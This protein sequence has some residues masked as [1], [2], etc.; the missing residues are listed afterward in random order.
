MKRPSRRTTIA[1]SVVAALL[2]ISSSRV[3]GRVT[4][5]NRVPIRDAHVWVAEDGEV[6]LRLRTDENGRFHAWHRP[7]AMHRGR[8]L[9][10]ARGHVIM[11]REHV[12]RAW[13]N[14]FG[15]GQRHSPFPPS[16]D[17]PKSWMLDLPGECLERV[18]ATS[19]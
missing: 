16:R 14:R 3:H 17:V 13:V 1:L 7:F 11:V 18:I 2:L 6:K 15:I 19:R 12:S 5:E 8:Q 4:D 10:C 9:I